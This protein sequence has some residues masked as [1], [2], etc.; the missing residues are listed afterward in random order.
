MPKKARM[1]PALDQ[2]Q[3]KH[4]FHGYK[5]KEVFETQEIV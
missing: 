1:Q 5:L 3:H 2:E 4:L